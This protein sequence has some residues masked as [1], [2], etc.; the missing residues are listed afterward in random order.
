MV[1][2]V[3]AGWKTSSVFVLQGEPGFGLPGPPGLPGIPGS[4]GFPGPK[5]DPG[6]PGTPGS[7]GR[8]GFDGGPGPKGIL[9]NTVYMLCVCS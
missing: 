3:E 2:V 5:G 4:K 7:P 9:N 1:V 8:S 6:F